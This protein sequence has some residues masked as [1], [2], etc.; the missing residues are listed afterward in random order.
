MSVNQKERVLLSIL[1]VMLM[2]AFL[3]Y[4]F[5]LDQYYC[6]SADDFAGIDYGSKGIPGF[7]YDWRFYLNWEGPFLSCLV[8]ALLMRL[9]SIGVTPSI[10]LLLVKATMVASSATL[11]K[12]ASNRITLNWGWTKAIF[13][14]LLFNITLYI[15]SPNQSEIW[16]WLIGLVYLIPLI[17]LQLGIAALLANRF[18]LAI[19]A[20]AFVMQSRA[21]YAVL[22]FGFIVL[23]TIFNWWQKAENRKQ[24]LLLSAFLFLF[25]ALYLIA[26]GNYVRLKE[27]GNSLP[28]LVTQFKIGLQNLFVSYNIAKMDR[29]LLGLLAVLPWV[30][31]QQKIVRPKQLWQWA[32]PAVLYV[33][34]AIAHE[35]LFV[36]VTGWRE[37]TRV[38]SLHSFLFLSMMFI[39]GFWVF[40]FVPV[41]WKKS[42]QLASFIGIGGLLFQLFNGFSHQLEMGKEL[43][44]NYDS[45]MVSILDH[46]GIEDTLYI[47]PMDYTGILYFNDFSEDPDHWINYD[48]RK[49]YNLDFKVA[50]E[51]QDE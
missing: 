36:Y 9:V 12:A 32:I 4:H 11:L 33:G 23:L 3:G 46:Q 21:T 25:L 34:F 38:L 6:L 47:R 41:S 26:P 29:V 24:W 17:F 50:L 31:F 28:F 20:L 22:I 16:H 30:G 45:R 27:H 49:A 2:L 5:L 1:N 44:T 39:Y 15:I 10:V 35:A 48:F 51:K 37:W 7:S 13:G 14:S 18:W 42:L 40:S 8:Q 43:K 19:A